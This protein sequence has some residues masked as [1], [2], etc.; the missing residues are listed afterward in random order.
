CPGHASR[1]LKLDAAVPVVFELRPERHSQSV[2]DERIFVL[3]ESADDC[4]GA[5]VR[6]ERCGWD[7]HDAAIAHAIASAPHD[8]VAI[9]PTETVLKIDVECVAALGDW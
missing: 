2:R 1:R 8:V 4:V 9:P 7:G 5:I 3:S 6:R